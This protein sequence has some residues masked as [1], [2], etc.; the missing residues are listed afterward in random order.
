MIKKRSLSRLF[1]LTIITFGIYMFF[2]WLKYI[3]DINKACICDGRES[4]N[5][6]VVLLLSVFTFGLYY[7][8]WTARQAERLKAIAP[9]YKLEFKEGTGTVFL[10]NILAV[11]SFTVAFFLSNFF[12]FIGGDEQNQKILTF[13]FG[14]LLVAVGVY[15][16]FYA[17]SVLINNLNAVAVV[18]NERCV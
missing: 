15:L 4:P 14:G 10:A 7:A 8:L 1:F 6:V 12:A 3:R 18:Y 13:A 2:F 5:A 16:S 17:I 11:L 9:E